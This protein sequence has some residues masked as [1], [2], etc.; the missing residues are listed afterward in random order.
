MREAFE[1]GVMSFGGWGTRPGFPLFHFAFELVEDFFNI[2]ALLVDDDK[3]IGGEF[4]LV[5]QIGVGGAV[6]GIGVGDAAQGFSVAGADEVLALDS[7]VSRIEWIM[8][9]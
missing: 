3:L 9:R 5:G 1:D 7:F 6:G 2:P 8:D 4:H